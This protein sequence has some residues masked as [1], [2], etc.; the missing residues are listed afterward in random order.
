[1]VVDYTSLDTILETASSQGRSYLHEHEVYEFL[2][3]MFD[4]MS[5]LVKVPNYSVATRPED[6][7]PLSNL[8]SVVMKV[9]PD[10]DVN[11]KLDHKSKHGGVKVVENTP[12]SLS[13]AYTRMGE[14][15][16]AGMKGVLLCEELVTGETREIL[17]STIYDPNMGPAITFGQGGENSDIRKRDR[18]TVMAN[19]DESALTGMMGSTEVY[20]ILKTNPRYGAHIPDQKDFVRVLQRFQE[21]GNHYSRLNTSAK[22]VIEEFECNPFLVALKSLTALD[23]LMYFKQAEELPL[24]KTAPNT[25]GL[26]QVIEPKSIVLVG[27]SGTPP[28]IGWAALV[29]LLDTFGSDNLYAVN[30]KGKPLKVY[31]RGNK[32]YD[33]TTYQSISDL[34]DGIDL[35]ILTIPPPFIPDAIREADRKGIKAVCIVASGFGEQKAGYGQQR[36]AELRKAVAEVDLR[37]VG[38]NCMGGVSGI[39]GREM[40]MLFTTEASTPVNLYAPHRNIGLFCQSGTIAIDNALDPYL[41]FRRMLTLGNSLSVDPADALAY[42]LQDSK[43]AVLG[44]YIENCLNAHCFTEVAR[45]SSRPI[46]VL[47]G[48]INELGE[49]AAHSHTAAALDTNK[50]FDIALKQAG[51]IV[52]DEMHELRDYL[53]AFSF[54][55]D[56]DFNGYRTAILTNAG[57]LGVKAS[58]FIPNATLNLERTLPA[59]TLARLPDLRRLTSNVESPLDITGGASLQ[60]YLGCLD[61]MLGDPEI[62]N[63]FL[64][65]VPQVPAIY[66]NDVGAELGLRYV[67][68][69]ITEVVQGSRKPVVISATLP[70][71]SAAYD[72]KHPLQQAGIPCYTSPEIAMR[73]LV[74]TVAHHM[75]KGGIN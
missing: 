66:F 75:G 35:A 37:V 65:I 6:L 59:E 11:P 14:T 57:A 34:P 31:G 24:I 54:L 48:G 69:Q 73:V 20:E 51:V 46:V 70:D 52:V 15:F 13:A 8:A 17:V 4:D 19:A 7:K 27:A 36:E 62:D 32:R 50:L 12:E 22:F 68:E 38:T 33:V 64:G 25:D 53:K 30:S 26:E 5:N 47:R 23:G 61:A 1:M 74:S 45:T 71:S 16:G 41:G 10:L 9:I 63:V 55:Y 60:Q 44:A 2:R 67:A 56:R 42:F 43:I 29:N 40:N 39:V 58:D 49:R 3:V 72:F 18:R 28:K 21:I